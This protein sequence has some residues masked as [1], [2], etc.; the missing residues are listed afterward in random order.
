M[1][2]L[3]ET[4]PAQGY[5]RRDLPRRAVK[6]K[7]DPTAAISGPAAQ[8]ARCDRVVLGTSMCLY[9]AFSSVVGSDGREEK[10]GLYPTRELCPLA[11]HQT[12]VQS[13][14]LLLLQA[15]FYRLHFPFKQIMGLTNV[16]EDRAQGK[17]EPGLHF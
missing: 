16:R 13:F 14:L 17:T 7:G 15:V 8:L 4:I 5:F 1:S 2:I 11:R 6:G 10:N 9:R 3:L 12:A